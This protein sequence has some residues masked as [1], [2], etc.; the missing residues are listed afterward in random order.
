MAAGWSMITAAI[1]RIAAIEKCQGDRCEAA[2][3]SRAKGHP[4]G[5]LMGA[6]LR[7]RFGGPLRE[8]R[9]SLGV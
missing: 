5:N 9:T 7:G 3:S 8:A 6:D 2:A 4:A 1:T